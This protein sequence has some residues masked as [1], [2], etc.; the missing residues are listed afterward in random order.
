MHELAVRA[1]LPAE[2]LLHGVPVPRERLFDVHERI[3][4]DD[5]ATFVEN[6]A[7]LCGSDEAIL[8][9]SRDYPRA[10]ALG[11]VPRL[12]QFVASPAALQAFFDRWIGPAN[13]R[14]MLVRSEHFPDGTYRVELTM[15]EPYKPSRGFLLGT[16][17][18]YEELPTMLGLPRAHVDATVGERHAVYRI[19]F[20]PSGTLWAHL[21]RRLGALRGLGSLVDLLRRQHQEVTAGLARAERQ[22]RDFEQLLGTISDGV[23]LLAGDRV[24]YA[25]PAL[26]GLLRVAD[27]ATLRRQP[28]SDR[29]D[30]A[31]RQAFAQ[32]APGTPRDLRFLPE[33]GPPAL[34][35]AAAHGTVLFEDTEAR[36][37]LLRDVTE[38]RTLEHEIAAAARRER[39]LIAHDLHDDAG[40]LLAGA[41]LKAGLHAEALTRTGSPHAAQAAELAALVDRCG[42]Q[43]RQLAHTLSPVA[44]AQ[45]GLGPALRQLT[46]HASSLFGLDCHCA[47]PF[48]K[49]IFVAPAAAAEVYRIVQESINN[50]IRH[51]RARRVALSLDAAAGGVWLAVEDDG[52]GFPAPAA[53][54]SGIGLKLMRHRAA[55]FGGRIEFGRASLGGARVACFL[56]GVTFAPPA[57]PAATPAAAPARGPA[58]PPAAD[59]RWRVVIADDHPV[60]RSGFAALLAQQP[61]LAVCA[62]IARLE[63]IAPACRRTQA[64]LLV[65]DLLF[66]ETLALDALGRLR[67]EFPALRILVVSM[68]PETAYSEP[69]RLAGADGFV[70]KQ[71]AAVA[72][73]RA[74]HAVLPG[75]PIP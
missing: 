68:F 30:A 61:G 66:G 53:P 56:P 6:W 37:V 57:A 48:P 75:A 15:P 44:L 1:G 28:F 51:G 72:M 52:V 35:E 64:D 12:A 43:L 60:F 73:I 62:E 8:R 32:L 46:T 23:V 49:E 16:A 22:R 50:A 21:R 65:L 29:L 3:D 13:V 24:L 18:V 59:G 36:L 33:S 11:Y 58:A 71:A 41:T 45:H 27:R 74:V 20:P 70:N 31:D 14:N 63:D 17:A 40:Q 39:E 9:V 19:T 5:F 26:L 34:C 10:R 42:R 7:K 47:E 69:V 25:N 67:A 54:A 55:S 38:R 4:W 2:K